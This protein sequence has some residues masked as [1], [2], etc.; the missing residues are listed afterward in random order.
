[1]GVSYTFL[2]CSSVP[3]QKK[4]KWS[5]SLI[6]VHPNTSIAAFWP[7]KVLQ[8]W[9]TLPLPLQSLSSLNS[10]S[11][12]LKGFSSCHELRPALHH[13]CCFSLLFNV[14][15]HYSTYGYS[16]SDLLCIVSFFLYGAH[17]INYAKLESFCYLTLAA[18][19]PT[20]QRHWNRICYSAHAVKASK[21]GALIK[22]P[23]RLNIEHNGQ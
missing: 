4:K 22:S 3:S 15:I 2:W 14:Y 21:V 20:Q 23:L 16:Y 19:S 7:S 10:L 12:N 18:F 6:A 9:N 11:L 13:Y 1:M 5:S 17:K 8:L